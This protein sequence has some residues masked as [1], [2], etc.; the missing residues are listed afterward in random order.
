MTSATSSRRPAGASPV[1]GDARVPGSY[2]PAAGE[3]VFPKSKVAVFVDGCFWHG[4]PEHGP[5]VYTTNAWYWPEKIERNQARDADTDAQLGAAGWQ[6]VRVW[7]HEA[8]ENAAQR[9]RAAVH[10]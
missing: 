1:P 5:R 3:I 10:Q 6:T 2:P 9:I 7:E 8:V 4:C